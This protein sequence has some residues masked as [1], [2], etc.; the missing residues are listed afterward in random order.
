MVQKLSTETLTKKDELCRYSLIIG[1]SRRARQIAE[2]NE[3]LG[4]Q[5]EEKPVITAAKEYAAKKG[6]VVEE[7]SDNDCLSGV[8]DRPFCKGRAY[9]PNR[10]TEE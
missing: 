9:D 8:K 6:V 3:E 10:Y 4:I 5:Y 2:K 7:E 1:I